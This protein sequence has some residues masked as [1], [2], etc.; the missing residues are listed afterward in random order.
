M[1]ALAL[2]LGVLP[3]LCGPAR[4]A[5]EPS[6]RNVEVELKSFVIEMPKE[7]PP[8]LTRFNCHNVG[9]ITHSF[10]IQGN[11]IDQ[12]LP[13][14]LGPEQQASVTVDLKPGTYQVWCP[15]G[16]HREMGMQ[17][18]LRVF[19][20]AADPKTTGGSGAA[21]EAGRGEKSAKESHDAHHTMGA[22]FPKFI[23][24]LGKFHPAA[25][26]FPIALILAAALAELLYMKGKRPFFDH[27][28]RFCVT[29][30]VIAALVAAV[31][32]WFF[33][34]LDLSRDKWILSIHRWFGT[35]TAVWLI[36]TLILSESCRKEGASPRSRH[37]FRLSLFLGAALV[38][39]TGF[40]GGS[41]LYGIKHYAYTWPS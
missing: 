8:G 28:C 15:V 4:A 27:A 21:G 12:S 11:G 32:G 3:L 34:G 24:W 33:A 29:F 37:W 38:M 2:I 18:T 25:V 40:F 14:N 6:P 17:L 20:G 1:R 36:L 35:A 22:G 7:L 16:N 41:L 5:P 9:Q 23:A 26:N 13:H 10:E 31:L 19:K 30:G 39:T